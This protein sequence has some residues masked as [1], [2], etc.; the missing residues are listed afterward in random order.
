MAG[1][2]FSGRPSSAPAPSPPAA[3]AAVAPAAGV[4]QPGVYSAF[5]G[6]TVYGVAQRFGVP[7]RTLIET[8]ALKPPYRLVAGQQLRVPVRQEHVVQAGDNLFA[9]SRI[10][11]VDQ[12]SLARAN[13]LE[14]PYGLRPGQRL[15][16]PGRIE[17]NLAALPPE[18]IAAPTGPN[19]GTTGAMAVEELPA[20]PRQPAPA[21]TPSEP[22]SAAASSVPAPTVSTTPVPAAP[23]APPEPVETPATKTPPEAEISAIPDTTDMTP[24]SS[25]RFLWP[26]EGK[27][28]S[29]F[30][31]KKGGLHNDGINIAAVAGANVVAAQDG[32]VAYA[33]NELRGF[34]NLLLIRH[35]N[36]WVTAYA[37]NEKL[38]VKQGDRV[39]RGQPIARVG[40]SGNVTSPQLHFEI[41]K[42]T[43]PV[44]P[45]EH[46]A[47][48]GVNLS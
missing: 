26:V 41:R 4:P 12:S 29:R 45:L 24:R 19:T 1:C 6:D 33:G 25:G 2:N 36:G 34:G 46:L 7:V 22:A 9:I 40:S 18:S 37:H 23:A 35:A 42:G 8:N 44:D 17:A 14:P 11:G 32:V 30:G 38:L 28:V 27:V 47:V 15:V 21:T 48:Q 16:L 13:S 31:A 20:L 10:Y 3:P 5:P 43:D 39:R